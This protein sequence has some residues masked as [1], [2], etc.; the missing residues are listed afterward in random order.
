MTA[1]TPPLKWRD[2]HPAAE[3]SP[4]MERDELQALADDIK[5]KGLCTEITIWSPHKRE[6]D[7]SAKMAAPHQAA[8]GLVHRDRLSTVSGAMTL[9][10]P[11]PPAVDLLAEAIEYVRPY[12][13]RT[14]LVHHRVRAFWA[15]VVVARDLGA[16][17][18]VEQEFTRLARD[19]GLTD[20]LGAAGSADVA[21][22]IRWG[23]IDRNPF[24]SKSESHA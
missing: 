24:C 22:L 12:L 13:D 11:P 23:L 4:L 7:C 6:R 21:H 5:L 2:V 9:H 14:R 18:V 3:L 16:L 19:S 17:D 1:P 8:G 20:D 10:V 15:G